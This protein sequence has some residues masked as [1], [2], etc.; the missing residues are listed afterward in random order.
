M[1]CKL[2]DNCALLIIDPQNDFCT[3]GALEVPYADNIFSVINKLRPL[4]NENRVFV[5][6][7]WHPSN[8]VSFASTHNKNLFQKITISIS[9]NEQI[10]Q[11][12]WPDHCVQNTHGAK[13]YNKFKLNPKDIVIKKG[14]MCMIDS[15][16]AFGDSTKNF[17]YEKTPLHELLQKCNVDTVYIVGLTYNYCVSFTAKDATLLNYK[18]YV[19]YDATQAVQNKSVKHETNEMMSHGVNLI[20]YKSLLK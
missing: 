3:G 1:T 16:S 17:E 2:G 18:T 6:Q 20:S 9:D 7:D 5:S 14:T 11:T 8:H 4:F 10:E 19:I 15:Y 12:L 13:F